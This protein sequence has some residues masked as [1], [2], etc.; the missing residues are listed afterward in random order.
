MNR[1]YHDRFGVANRKV[2]AH[3]PHMIDRGIMEEMQ[4]TFADEWRR[5]AG[6][7]FRS[8]QDMQY[9]FSYFYYL[10]NRYALLDMNAE[11]IFR[12]HLDADG[13]GVLSDNEVRTLVAMSS[14]PKGFAERKAEIIDCFMGSAVDANATREAAAPAGVAATSWSFTRRPALA[15][16]M[17][18]APAMEG[19]RQFSFGKGLD[20]GLPYPPT[21]DGDIAHVAFEMLSNDLNETVAR[22]D[23]VRSRRTKF[24][25]I[26]DNRDA[27]SEEEEAALRDFFESFFSEP[28]PFELPEGRVNGALRTSEYRR[29][30][31]G[32]RAG[33]YFWPAACLLSVLCGLALARK[34]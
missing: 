2:P 18:C 25:S 5:T 13:D 23:S 11:A 21:A 3:M 29:A 32:R 12:R 28:S 9:A 19:L 31:R 10:K 14:D 26:N 15:D 20:A 34:R 33:G 7:R 16:V 30:R 8:A 24:I 22:L 27:V 1:L 4:S 17:A 6:R